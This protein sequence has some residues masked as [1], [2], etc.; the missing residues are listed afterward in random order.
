MT[1]PPVAKA[2]WEFDFGG[3]GLDEK[4]GLSRFEANIAVLRGKKWKYVQFGAASLPALLFDMEVRPS[5][6]QHTSSPR[7]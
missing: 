4:L 2:H 5:R 6:V 3:G 7:H 1:L